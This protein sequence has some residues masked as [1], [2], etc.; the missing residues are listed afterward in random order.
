[1]FEQII[2]FFT[3][4]SLEYLCV[5]SVVFVR[6]FIVEGF[7]VSCRDMRLISPSHPVVS[8]NSFGTILFSSY[9]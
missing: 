2:V 6:A 4:S 9:Q 3:S 7:Q 5:V 8:H 1:M